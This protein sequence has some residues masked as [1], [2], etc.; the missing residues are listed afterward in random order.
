MIPWRK[1]LLVVF[2]GAGAILVSL[3]VIFVVT[4]IS[5]SRRKTG[6]ERQR[7]LLMAPKASEVALSN[8]GVTQPN[9]GT[10]NVGTGNVSAGTPR[11]FRGH[12]EG[13]GPVKLE[14]YQIVCA[15]GF[16]YIHFD[17]WGTNNRAV[18]APVF[19]AD[20]LPARCGALEETRIL[21]AAPVEAMPA[22]PS[23]V[24]ETRTIEA[25]TRGTSTIILDIGNRR[26]VDGEYETWS[27]LVSVEI[28]MSNAKEAEAFKA[29]MEKYLCGWVLVKT[30]DCGTAKEAK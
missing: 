24:G 9:V 16:K 23:P 18:L 15:E 28:P 4:D 25:R 5:E 19:D 13:D 26:V 11:V 1:I 6:E 10:G 21:K 14:G 12:R 20:R 27:I 29:A 22:D 17:Y 7:A 2:F 30:S 8:G 3:C